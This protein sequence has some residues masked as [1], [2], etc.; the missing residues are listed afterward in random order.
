MV[1]PTDERAAPCNL[2]AV[3]NVADIDD[4]TLNHEADISEQVEIVVTERNSG[5]SFT[6]AGEDLDDALRIARVALADKARYDDLRMAGFSGSEIYDLTNGQLSLELDLDEI[7]ELYDLDDDFDRSDAGDS[8]R[9]GY[10]AGVL[11]TGELYAAALA[12]RIASLPSEAA[13]GEPVDDGIVN[14][15]RIIPIDGAFLALIMPT[16]IATD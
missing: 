5:D 2:H 11:E 4:I 14:A 8:W 15:L 9:R 6:C 1:E 12:S 3:F 10:E 13:V 7:E 16:Q